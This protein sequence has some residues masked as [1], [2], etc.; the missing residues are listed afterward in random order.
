MPRFS[1]QP[2]SEAPVGGAGDRIKID[3]VVKDERL[4]NTLNACTYGL[5]KSG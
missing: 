3:D 1:P 5:D 4:V 2:L